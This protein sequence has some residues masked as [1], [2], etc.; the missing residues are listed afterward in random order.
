M[1]EII[2][3]F[4]V[5]IFSNSLFQIIL[6]SEIIFFNGKCPSLSMIFVIR[7]GRLVFLSRILLFLSSAF[8]V[9]SSL[10]LPPTFPSER[11]FDS[12]DALT[13]IPSGLARL[14]NNA[15]ILSRV[16][17]DGQEGI[18]EKLASTPV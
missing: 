3:F 15:F 10:F 16:M 12:S 4:K 8:C 13:I 2:F 1:K 17:M 7:V 6:R 9:P 5:L 14:L 11:P 18:E